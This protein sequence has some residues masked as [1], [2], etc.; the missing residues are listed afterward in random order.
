MEDLIPPKPL[1]TGA[2]AEW[3]F[4]TIIEC[5]EELEVLRIK[6]HKNGMNGKTSGVFIV[7]TEERLKLF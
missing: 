7:A 6:A 2:S 1:P 5:L 3:H 4:D